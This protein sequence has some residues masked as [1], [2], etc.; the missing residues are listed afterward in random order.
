MT[1]THSHRTQTTQPSATRQQ[2]RGRG[3]AAPDE[4]RLPLRRNKTP[5]GTTTSN[6]DTDSDPAILAA[7]HPRT[8]PRAQ[9][10]AAAAIV[11]SRSRWP[12]RFSFSLDSWRQFALLVDRG[13]LVSSASSLPLLLL[14]CCCSPP[15]QVCLRCTVS[16]GATQLRRR[17]AFDGPQG[18]T[19]NQSCWWTR[20]GLR[21][22][23][24]ATRSSSDV[25]PADAWPAHPARAR[26]RSEAKRPNL[27]RLVWPRVLTPRWVWFCAAVVTR[28]AAAASP[29]PRRRRHGSSLPLPITQRNA[30]RQMHSDPR[31]R[32]SRY[33][34]CSRRRPDRRRRRYR[35]RP[36]AVCGC[37]SCFFAC[38]SPL[39]SCRCRCC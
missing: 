38:L 37:R 31:P 7:T 4:Q 1:L 22:R 26:S 29:F 2:R 8:A 13:L 16:R 24:P 36:A 23:C 35:E 9:R 5:R 33:A 32:R 28:S 18:T 19:R 20:F 27:R 3:N 30:A 39:V 34:V 25:C 10:N 21:P 15:T 6:D 11:S 17:N 12:L 14:R